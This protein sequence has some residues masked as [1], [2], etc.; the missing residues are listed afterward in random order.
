MF[1]LQLISIVAYCQSSDEIILQVTGDLNSDNLPDEVI[2]KKDSTNKDYPFILNV[3]LNDKNERTLIAVSNKIILQAR[4]RKKIISLESYCSLK[5]ENNKLIVD[6][7]M[8]SER[9]IYK[10]GYQDSEFILL[11]YYGE[12]N[13]GKGKQIENYDSK[14]ARTKIVIKD[15]SDNVTARKE[16]IE[17]TKKLE[18]FE[19]NL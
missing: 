17:P 18:N 6:Y 9:Y 12:F 7:N 11:E 4:S 15:K 3:F 19:V 10:F 16:R 1:F 8:D 13:N 5:I 2:V 14:S